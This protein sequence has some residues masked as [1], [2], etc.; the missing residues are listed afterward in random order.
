[1]PSNPLKVIIMGGSLGGLSTGHWLKSLGYDVSIFERSTHLMHGKGAGLLL[2]PYT[3]EY[4]KKHQHGNVDSFSTSVNSLRF[5]REDGQEHLHTSFPC[6][7]TSYPA[8][9][10]VFL[11]TFGNEHYHLGHCVSAISQDNNSVT[12][13]TTNGQLHSCDFLVCADGTKSC[14]RRLLGLGDQSKYSGYVAWRGVTSSKS[15]PSHAREVGEKSALYQLRADSHLIAV[16]MPTI[17]AENE[18][19]T[20]EKQ[21]NWLWYQHVK[22]GKDLDSILTD[23]FGELREKSVPPG[24]V[25]PAHIEKLRQDGKVL[26]SPFREFLEATDH[27]FIQAVYDVEVD[28]MVVGRACILGDAAFSI[29]PHLAVGTAKAVED[30]HQLALHL[31]K[32][33]GDILDALSEWE[34]HQMNL[35]KSC[36]ARSRELGNLLMAGQWSMENLP[37]FGL[38]EAGDS[39]MS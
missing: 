17:T 3:V 26:P 11:K 30:G 28:R 12:V 7:F 10:D 6:K 35:G 16:P 14:A 8:L 24:L 5:I 13:T 39:Q 25:N 31:E 23:K 29:R 1:M 37:P 34:V 36:V 27:P 21:I 19:L 15:L 9:Y 4:V 20:D 32:S 33:K 38:Y 2:S 22:D 18:I